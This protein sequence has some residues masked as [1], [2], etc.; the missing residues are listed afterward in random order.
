MGNE[1]ILKDQLKEL[2]PSKATQIEAVFAPMVQ[3]LKS[4]EGAYSELMK[5]EQSP[6]KAK[7]AK[8]LRLDI[9]KIRVSADKERKSQKEEYI[10]AGKAIQG[11]YNIL[12][13][14]VKD[15]EDK[16]K[17]V[18]TYEERLEQERLKMIQVEREAELLKYSVSDSID[19]SAMS[20]GSMSEEVY[21]NFLSGS[22]ANYEAKIQA[23]QKAE[24]DRIEAERVETVY[25]SR[26]IKLGSYARFGSLEKLTREMTED[27]YKKHLSEM[28][29]EEDDYELAVEE[30][31]IENERL[32]KE[33][34]EREKK[35]AIEREKLK[36]ERKA[37]EIEIQK[38]REA[39]EAVERKAR[40]EKLAAE[41]KEADRI[42]AESERKRK[43]A[44]EK[45]KA[46]KE[47]DKEKL[48]GFARTLIILKDSVKSDEAKTAIS[49]AISIL[50]ET[51]NSL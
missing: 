50:T 43:E 29:K 14:A 28:I 7:K 22:K 51:A 41:K 44:E 30:T 11:V 37:K 18:E 40:E 46:E 48:I 15:K 24:E 10:R 34:E 19:Y 38:E 39:R 32:R 12:E 6:E 27:E 45:R 5:E 35:E 2:E 20:L 47:P 16:L 23:E 42:K 4:F 13:H 3:M 31:R 21:N 8:R 17:E 9:A 36:A 33:A 1:L 49:Q 26:R 25:Q